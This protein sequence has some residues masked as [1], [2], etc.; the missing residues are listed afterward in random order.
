LETG[1]HESTEG[2][3][4]NND[5]AWTL[6]NAG[7]VSSQGGGALRMASSVGGAIARYLSS[8]FKTLSAKEYLRRLNTCEDCEHYTGVRCRVCGCFAQIKARLPHEQCPL[9]KW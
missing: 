8:G 7:G 1:V 4:T 3:V 2:D 6:V 5:L 9:E